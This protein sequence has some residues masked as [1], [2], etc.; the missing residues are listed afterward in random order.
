MRIHGSYELAKNLLHKKLALRA[1][2]RHLDIRREVNFQMGALIDSYWEQYGSRKKS[3]DRE[4]AFL[5]GI[6]GSLGHLFV[7]E[8]DGA[9]VER[10]YRSLT[11]EK[12][13]SGHCRS[14]LQ[15]HAPHDEE[16]RNN[17]VHEKRY[18]PES[19]RYG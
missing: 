14:P 8:V 6:R 4:K 5:E 7:R 3:Q 12:T 15:R 9:A 11:E 1:E 18:R 10:W 17:L 2:N 19:R 13:V 16:G